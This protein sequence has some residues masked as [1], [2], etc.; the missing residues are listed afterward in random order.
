[1]NDNETAHRVPLAVRRVMLIIPRPFSTT[2]IT[3]A[4]AFLVVAIQYCLRANDDNIYENP[5]LIG[6]IVCPPHEIMM[7]RLVCALWSGSLDTLE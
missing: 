1:M 3:L 2:T 5:I 4:P 6:L 7:F